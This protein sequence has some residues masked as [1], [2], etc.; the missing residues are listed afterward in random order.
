MGDRQQLNRRLYSATSESLPVS[1]ASAGT[2]KPQGEGKELETTQEDPVE[3]EQPPIK[4]RAKDES[5]SNSYARRTSRKKKHR[6][7]RHNSHH[8][9]WKPGCYF[10]SLYSHDEVKTGVAVLCMLV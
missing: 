2:A 4:P 8:G 7:T 5:S 9:E 1:M 3:P 6:P 10:R